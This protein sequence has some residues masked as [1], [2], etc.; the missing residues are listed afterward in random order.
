MVVKDVVSS[1]GCRVPS[2]H[3][4]V[5]ITRHSTDFYSIF[6]TREAYPNNKSI[7]RLCPHN[8]PSIA[9]TTT[10]YLHRPSLTSS[11]ASLADVCVRYLRRDSRT[12]VIHLEIVV[13]RAGNGCSAAPRRSSPFLSSNGGYHSLQHGV[14]VLFQWLS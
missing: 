7:P 1:A 3:V 4:R 12:S 8:A 2:L 11:S 5:M 9:G 13:H 14:S 10:T 6:R